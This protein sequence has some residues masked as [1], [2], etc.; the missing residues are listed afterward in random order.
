MTHTVIDVPKK[1]TI[2]LIESIDD[3]CAETMDITENGLETNQEN[4]VS[5]TS[6]LGTNTAPSG[7]LA[8]PLRT[9]TAVSQKSSRKTMSGMLRVYIWG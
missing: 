2:Q 8:T 7:G 1:I 5:A 9:V 6:E 3:V 4:I